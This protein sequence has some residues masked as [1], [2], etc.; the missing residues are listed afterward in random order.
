MAAHTQAPGLEVARLQSS[1]DSPTRLFVEGPY[2]DMKCSADPTSPLGFVHAS[3]VAESSALIGACGVTGA[4]ELLPPPPPV[5]GLLPLGRLFLVVVLLLV[6]P[7]SLIY[8][9]S[10]EGVHDFE[11]DTR[12]HTFNE[13]YIL[14]H[15]SSPSPNK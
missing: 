3:P 14:V 8:R 12:Y 10:M 7:R 15:H 5:N 4:A 1:T 11:E 6:S 13:I 9:R 2:L